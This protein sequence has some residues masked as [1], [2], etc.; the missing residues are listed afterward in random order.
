MI[1]PGEVHTIEVHPVTY[2]TLAME[3]MNGTSTSRTRSA[4]NSL[5]RNNSITVCKLFD[6]RPRLNLP[7]TCSVVC[8]KPNIL[9]EETTSA[10]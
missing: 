9:C 2:V 7:V 10:L 6:D 5:P 4:Q 1:L 3:K 8:T